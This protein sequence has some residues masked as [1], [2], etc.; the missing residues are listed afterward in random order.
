[1]GRG[2]STP[3]SRQG[4]RPRRRARAGG[5]GA[6]SSALTS[7]RRV[8]PVSPPPPSAASA[9]PAGVPVPPGGRTPVE[10]QGTAGVEQAIEIVG[11]VEHRRPRQSFGLVAGRGTSSERPERQ[12]VRRVDRLARS[13]PASLRGRRLHRRAGDGTAAAGAHGDRRGTTP[14]AAGARR[15]GDGR[16][17]RR[18]PLAARPPITAS[19]QTCR[20]LRVEPVGDGG[21]RRATGTLA[22]TGH[23]RT[24]VRW[25]REIVL[26]RRSGPRSTSCAAVVAATPTPAACGGASATRNTTAPARTT[27]IRKSQ[28]STVTR[29]GP[30]ERSPRGPG[31]R[32]AGRRSPRRCRRCPMRSLAMRPAE[33]VERRQR[34]LQ[35]ARSDDQLVAEGAQ[36]LRHRLEPVRRPS[37]APP[38][39]ESLSPG[40]KRSIPSITSATRSAICAVPST[41]S[42]RFVRAASPSCAGRRRR[43]LGQRSD[44]FERVV[45]AA[46]EVGEISRQTRGR[47][48]RRGCHGCGVL[49]DLER[50]AVGGAD[51]F[52]R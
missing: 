51:A 37:G 33:C 19:S 35:V 49:G 10:Q 31:R 2:A 18:S 7:T 13:F 23:G 3:G 4:R 11:L 22:S 39:S 14:A 29:S 47:I 43:G 34:R 15:R 21:R 44:R 27:A 6:S 32:R 24:L 5:Q 8:W 12:L 40:M 48:G 16:A 50:V 38:P 30:L 17:H 46:G 36:L 20:P 41:E 26:Y 1:M 42:A 52:A 25:A 45:D 28:R 9:P